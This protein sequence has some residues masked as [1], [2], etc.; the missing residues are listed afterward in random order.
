MLVSVAFIAT[1]TRFGHRSV[2][3]A[4]A[5]IVASQANTRVMSPKKQQLLLLFFR[6]Y[7]MTDGVFSMT[8]RKG[9]LH[10]TLPPYGRQSDDERSD[11]ER[12]ALDS[13]CS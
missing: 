8:I 9:W 12:G 4:L 13:S 10:W 5:P 7:S 3:L 2:T 6:L 1:L 11:D